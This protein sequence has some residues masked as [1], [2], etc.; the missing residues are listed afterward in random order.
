MTVITPGL[1]NT[2]EI[3]TAFLEDGA[4]TTVKLA[5]N[6]VTTAKIT[7]G[8]VTNAKL[9]NDTVTI[10]TNALALGGSLVLDTDDIGEG[11]TNQ[12]FTDA[13]AIAAVEGEATLDLSGD[14]DI[15]GTLT[16]ANNTIGDFSLSGAYD[17]TGLQIIA[18]NNRWAAIEI[19]EF[20]SSGNPFSI[21][22]P[23]FNSVVGEGTA[24]APTA[25]GD[26]KRIFSMGGTAFNGSTQPTSS[27]MLIIG[28]TTEAQTNTNRGCK[29]EIQTIGNGSTSR[30]TTARFA[31]NDT[32]LIN[33]IASGTVVLENLPTTDPVN[34]GQLWNDS[35]TLKVSAGS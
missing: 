9:A 19:K 3:T 13:R 8:D 2:G 15:T 12:Y 34:T 35:G 18:D 27:N 29:M 32:T 16:Q 1:I 33:L 11:T 23:G 28:S 31:G 14:V 26:S 22:N 30:S 24:A 4:V 17:A 21:F 5:T 10:N 25:V 7:D 20:G 6:A